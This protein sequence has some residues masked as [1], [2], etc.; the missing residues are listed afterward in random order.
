MRSGRPSGQPSRRVRI[1]PI[2]DDDIR[3]GEFR[4]LS[5]KE[6]AALKRDSRGR[7]N[8]RSASRPSRSGRRASNDGAYS[9]SSAAAQKR[10]SVHAA[11]AAA[12]RS[13]SAWVISGV[14]SCQ[15][16]TPRARASRRAAPTPSPGSRC[17]P[18][19]ATGR[20]ELAAWL[21]RRATAPRRRQV[22]QRAAAAPDPR[23]ATSRVLT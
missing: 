16:V 3:P 21:P 6:V 22:R 10:T 7:S 19:R 15:T 20:R 8:R 13:T 4:D 9:E 17:H 11:P 18:C 1:G 12:E 5:E 2:T 14:A 23:C